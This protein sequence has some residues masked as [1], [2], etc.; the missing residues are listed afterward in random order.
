MSSCGASR[1]GIE[2]RE[3]GEEIEVLEESEDEEVAGDARAGSAASR[4]VL[5][6]ELG[7]EPVDEDR[8]REQRHEA[9]VPVAVEEERE[10]NR[11]AGSRQSGRKRSTA[12]C[13]RSAAGRK[14]SRKAKELNSIEGSGRA[15]PARARDLVGGAMWRQGVAVS[16]LSAR[17][18]FASSTLA[19]KLDMAE[20]LVEV[21]IVAWGR[22]A[23]ELRGERRK[24]VVAMRS[25]RSAIF[26]RSSASRRSC[27]RPRPAPALARRIRLPWTRKSAST[28]ASDAARRCGGRALCIADRS[29]VKRCRATLRCRPHEERRW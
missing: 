22:V 18:S 1:P 9:P 3:V 24:L 2:V 26:S 15:R 25:E 23:R 7:D 5:T 10:R 8:G 19:R 4:L 21:R 14:T 17:P 12:Q 13:S 27:P 29:S 16:T 6:E 28:V 20:K 11:E